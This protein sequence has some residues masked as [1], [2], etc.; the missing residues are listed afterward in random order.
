MRTTSLLLASL[1]VGALLSCRGK[2][3]PQGPQGP[4]GPAGQDLVRPRQGVI[5]GTARGRDNDGN[6]F[7]IPFSY[8]FYLGSPGTWRNVDANTREY[9]FRREDSLGIGFVELTF[10]HNASNNQISNL[11]IDGIAANSSDRPV[12]TYPITQ[13]PSVPNFFPGTT[14]TISNIAFS[15]DSLSGRFTYIR[16]AYNNVP[17]VGTNTHADTVEGSFSVR[18]VPIR[19]YNRISPQ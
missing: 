17:G 10:R 2:E 13:L 14:Q 9:S 19:T 5:Q 4:Q 3:G 11:T 12:P 8:S 6:A 15:G 7:N 18:L 16:P 1:L